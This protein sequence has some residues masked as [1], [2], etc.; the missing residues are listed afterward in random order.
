MYAYA[1][2]TLYEMSTRQRR[3]HREAGE[4][5]W[6]R[7]SPGTRQPRYTRQ[8]IAA[9]ALAIADAEGI[10]AV[11]MRHVA[12][13]L[14]AGTMT[15]YHYVQTKRDL[16]TLMVDAVVGELL[17]PDAELAPGWREA[18]SQIARRSR[19]AYR[20]HPWMIATQLDGDARIAPNGMRHVE[21]SL[22]AVAAT[23]LSN[24]EK[25]ELIS[26]VD[27]YV[28]GFTVR[29][30]TGDEFSDEWIHAVGGYL[31]EQLL[32]GDF[33]HVREFVGDDDPEA[34]IRRIATAATADERFE[35]GLTRLLDGVELWLS[36]R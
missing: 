10:E 8:Q 30:D 16:L 26:L 34:V 2:S 3:P 33:P 28:F 14:G 15:V 11:S 31:A 27:D 18:L 22:A 24:E 6:T 29:S 1:S 17:V 7:P 35:R 5:V 4:P 32:S 13:A 9:V 36:K 12:R 20:R 19:A 23:P 25:M 21:Q